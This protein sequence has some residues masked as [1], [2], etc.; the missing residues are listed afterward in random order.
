MEKKLLSIAAAIIQ[1]S[2]RENPADAVLRSHLKAQRGLSQIQ[3]AQVTRTVFGCF[4]WFGWLDQ[5]QPLDDQIEHALELARS[6]V[7]NPAEFSDNDLKARAVPSWLTGEM[8]I[9]PDWARAIQSEPKLWLRAR[10][11]RGKA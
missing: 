11:G 2:N 1:R 6:F 5:Q 9:T 3:S 7:N 10:P 8:E 4:R